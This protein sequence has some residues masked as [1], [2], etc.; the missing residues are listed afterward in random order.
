[1]DP[2]KVKVVP[3]GANID[4]NHS[5]E[6]IKK[7]VEFRFRNFDKCSLLFCGVD[8]YRKGGDIALEIVI[9][10]KT[11]RGKEILRKLFAHSHF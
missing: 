9:S 4:C 8:W 6:Y 11:E 10:K 3:F 5:Y 1:M 2:E 7:L